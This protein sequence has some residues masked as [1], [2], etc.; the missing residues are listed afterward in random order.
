MPVLSS[1][2][3]ASTGASTAESTR[4]SAPHGRRS[5]ASS[6]MHSCRGNALP[7]GTGSCTEMA[8][9]HH[10]C[11][12]AAADNIFSHKHVPRGRLADLWGTSLRVPPCNPNNT[13]VGGRIDSVRAP[14]AALHQ[15]AVRNCNISERCYVLPQAP[16][17][18]DC[19]RPRRPSR[20]LVT[21]TKHGRW[22]ECARDEQTNQKCKKI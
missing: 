3:F 14:W 9:A 6:R 11:I 1:A 18:F 12:Y 13:R 2:A 4:T 7:A 10:S 16:R 21:F 19:G 22:P 17:R 5:P 20:R 8:A 15:R